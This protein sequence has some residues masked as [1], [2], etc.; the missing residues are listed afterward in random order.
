MRL[1][2]IIIIFALKTD[3]MKWINIIGLVLGILTGC[4]DKFA[5]GLSD[6]HIIPDVPVYTQ[7]DLGIGGES[8][9]QTPFQPLYLTVSRP[10]GEPLGYGGHGII[11]I[12]FND[13]EFACWDATCTNCQDLTSHFEQKDLNGEIAV[14][15]VCHAEFSLRYGSAFNSVTKIYPLKSYSITKSGNKLIISGNI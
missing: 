14:C 8:N 3:V 12:R 2:S 7:I 15:P 13:T 4:S 10:S 6:R 5:A 9:L 11:V 1:L